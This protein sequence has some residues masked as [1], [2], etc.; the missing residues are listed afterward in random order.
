MATWA[1]PAAS[2][3]RTTEDSQAFDA[4]LG[5]PLG[6]PFG[7]PSDPAT[8]PPAAPSKTSAVIT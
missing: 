6:D 2:V 1:V 7:D 8:A 5:D 4:P 3:A